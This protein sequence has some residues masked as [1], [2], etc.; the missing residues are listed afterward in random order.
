MFVDKLDRPWL[1]TPFLLQGLLIENDD[2]IALLKAQCAFVFVDPA[3]STGEAAQ[4]LAKAPPAPEPAPAALPPPAPSGVSKQLDTGS[5]NAPERL[6]AAPLLK[7]RGNK[8]IPDEDLVQ[9]RKVL[10]H[11]REM[12]SNVLADIRNRGDRC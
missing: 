6:E 11:T 12:V 1:G 2:D 10:D 5:H 3:R 4:Q 9:A 8:I 7:I